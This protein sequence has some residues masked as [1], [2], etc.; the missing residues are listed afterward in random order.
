[1]AFN[2]GFG[3][4]FARNGVPC[5][6]VHTPSRHLAY[7]RIMDFT[8]CLLWPLS[9]F[10][11]PRV[12]LIV[13]DVI[14]LSI[15]VWDILPL[16]LLPFAGV[17]GPFALPVV[18]LFI[19]G[20]QW[21]RGDIPGPKRRPHQKEID[22]AVLWAQQ[23]QELLCSNGKLI[24]CGYSSGGHCASLYAGTC[25]APPFDSVV[26]ISGIYGLRTHTWS[27]FRSLLAPVFDRVF[28]DILGVQTNEERDSQSPDA[29][30]RREF[31]G[32]D[33]YILS[34]KKELMGL[35]PFED[36]LFQPKTLCDALVAKGAKVHRVTCGLNHW[37]LVLNI[38]EFV[39]PFCEGLGGEKK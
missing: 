33:W 20:F 8:V 39:R 23:H 18:H 9:W 6:Q 7:T 26:L 14:M 4:A 2:D 31:N 25:A 11:V 19:R 17:L 12:L 32:Q 16:L 27:G 34:A 28:S 29:M 30:I 21:L 13:G 22:A 3:Y 38:E 5:V 10:Y 37:V 24:L 1:M 15:I 36:I 35:Q